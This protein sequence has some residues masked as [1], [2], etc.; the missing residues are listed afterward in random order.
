MAGIYDPLRNGKLGLV[1]AAGVAT[2][3]TVAPAQAQTQAS[4]PPTNPDVTVTYGGSRTNIGGSTANEIVNCLVEGDLMPQV[5]EYFWGL[6]A[7]NSV[8]ITKPSFDKRGAL[9]NAPVVAKRTS[10][11]GD[12]AILA[13]IPNGRIPAD[14][15]NNYPLGLSYSYE[16][17]D[18]G[19]YRFVGG[20]DRDYNP[21]DPNALQVAQLKVDQAIACVERRVP[22]ATNIID[23]AKNSSG[24]SG[25]TPNPAIAPSKIEYSRK[26]MAI[27]PRR[28][29]SVP[30]QT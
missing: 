29:V 19:V 21:K 1:L 5:P 12:I 8:T 22:G 23:S 10:H 4:A 26:G 9:K 18:E 14:P 15:N 11:L 3:P 28:Q 20:N 16:K 2:L 17:L 6:G 7:S 30:G 13:V 25:E 27:T 24:Q